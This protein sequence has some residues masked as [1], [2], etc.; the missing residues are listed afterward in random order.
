MIFLKKLIINDKLGSMI[1]SLCFSI[2]VGVRRQRSLFFVTILNVVFVAIPLPLILCFV[3]NYGFEGLLMG[4]V[5]S[6]LVNA[7]GC[8]FMSWTVNWDQEIINARERS[9]EMDESLNQGKMNES[10]EI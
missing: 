4:Y 1:T 2:L 5:A 8:V 3:L 10:V 6:G 7:I 9:M